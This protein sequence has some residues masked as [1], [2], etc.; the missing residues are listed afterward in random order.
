[1]AKPIRE[2]IAKYGD[3]LPR[4]MRVK[5][6][7]YWRSLPDGVPVTI[8]VKRA[9]RPKTDKQLGY[10]WGVLLPIVSEE[11]GYT[12]NEAHAILMSELMPDHME[13]FY[14]PIRQRNIQNRASLAA[15]TTKDV[16]DLFER[17][18]VY[19][20]DREIHVPHPKDKNT[21]EALTE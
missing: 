11:T 5:I 19:L 14:C 3:W 2:S 13:V 16:A 7:E 10:W 12:K 8:V 9:S 21:I 1:M 15:M 20:S 6:T 4:T 18:W 17:A